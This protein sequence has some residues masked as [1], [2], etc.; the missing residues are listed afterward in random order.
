MKMRPKNNMKKII[1]KLNTI[2]RR[3]V[4]YSLITVFGL[5]PAAFIY[6]QEVPVYDLVT[7]GGLPGFS[8]SIA[9][10]DSGFVAF[11]RHS[12]EIM[13]G[14]A[15][16]LAVVMIIYGGL[17][18]MTSAASPSKSNAKQTI[19]NSLLGLLLALSAFIILNTINPALVNIR[20]IQSDAVDPG[21]Y[22]GLISS[23]EHN[24]ILGWKD[25]VS[26]K[27][28]G[29][30]TSEECEEWREDNLLTE[31][32]D[33]NMV[34][35]EGV[36]IN[37]D[38]GQERTTQD[39]IGD[40]GGPAAGWNFA[41][42]S[43]QGRTGGGS[44][45]GGYIWHKED[46]YEE[47]VTLRESMDVNQNQ[48][49]WFNK[50]SHFDPDKEPCSGCS[51][52]P[53]DNLVTLADPEYK[54]LGDNHMKGGQ[55][56]WN[57]YNGKE[58][59]ND[60]MPQN[61]R[62]ACRV[63]EELAQLLVEGQENPPEGWK[64]LVQAAEDGDIKDWQITEAWPPTVTHQANCHKI[65]TCVDIGFKDKDYHSD[66]SPE[67]IAKFIKAATKSG[68]SAIFETDDRDLCKAVFDTEENGGLLVSEE[69]LLYMP[70]ENFTEHF[71][72]YSGNVDQGGCSWDQQ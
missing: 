65:G 32:E 19:Q 61:D 35:K 30:E 44:S 48:C 57:E 1:N 60:L 29:F 47:C 41:E 70:Q 58:D 9:V 49:L 31:D 36:T 51:A 59:E 22:D 18:Y 27:S 50:A 56:Q 7:E 63:D 21:I 67:E 34:L 8:D 55:C 26:Q 28:K 39:P 2:R 42:S 46:T 15:T 20:G 43:R 45:L 69:K 3:G 68:L 62:E 66:E 33:G 13:I 23:D 64:S 54:I 12:I 52:M 71:S 10:S 16:I 14:F 17:K 40:G 25:A 11:I 37:N 53:N 6:A 24:V 5:A 4:L 38:C 72:V